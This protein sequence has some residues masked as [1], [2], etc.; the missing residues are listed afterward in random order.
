MRK[1][2]IYYFKG[3]SY[4]GIISLF[5]TPEYASEGVVVASV[6][7][8][9]GTI[10]EPMVTHHRTLLGAKRKYEAF[11]TYA[12]ERDDAVKI[13]KEEIEA[14]LDKHNISLT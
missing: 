7:K 9:D 4:Y 2:K 5:F 1:D 11:I 3:K 10:E 12:K 13:S 8:R 14:F 6:I